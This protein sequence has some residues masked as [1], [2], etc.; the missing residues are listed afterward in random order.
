[1]VTVGVVAPVGDDRSRITKIGGHCF[2]GS[3][4]D[5]GDRH[6]RLSVL[7]GGEAVGNDR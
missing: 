4:G 6:W 3:T 1:M 7:H 2:V 5:H